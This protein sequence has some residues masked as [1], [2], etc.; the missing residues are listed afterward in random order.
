MPN[1]LTF[2]IM[3]L[4]SIMS[5]PR[6]RPWHTILLLVAILSLVAGGYALWSPGAVIEDGRH[7]RGANGIWIQHGWL[8][9][10]AW[11][12]RYARDPTQFRDAAAIHAL[13]DTLA[14]HNITDVFPHLCPCSRDGHIAR[15]DDAQ[16]ELLLREFKDFRVMPWIGGVVDLHVFLDSKDWRRTF[17]DSACDLLY[18]HPGFAGVHIN[19]E[20]LPSGNTH[21]LTLLEE[22]RASLP[23]GKLL[24]VAAYPPPTWLHPFP[25]VHWEKEYFSSV[26]NRVDQVAVMMYDTAI[27]FPKFY[28]NLMRSWTMDVLDWAGTNQVLL[29]IPVYDDAG[30]GYHHARVENL[31]NALRGI[32]AGLRNFEPCPQSYQG[33]ALYCEWEMDGEEWRYFTA[34]FVKPSSVK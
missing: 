6:K 13:A 11:F 4:M 30:V 18:Q 3:L 9:D 26:C 24:S 22:I 21:F 10:D 16:A 29:G 19:I 1:E 14:A 27:W 5:A 15:V 31:H 33:V 8:G 20:P 25:V 7:D 2:G 34:H 32:H 23:D 17:I 12:N 28:T